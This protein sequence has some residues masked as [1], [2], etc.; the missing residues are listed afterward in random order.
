MVIII[1]TVDNISEKLW[2]DLKGEL[3]KIAKLITMSCIHYAEAISISKILNLPSYILM[4]R[5]PNQYSPKFPACMVKD[6]YKNLCLDQFS[7]NIILHP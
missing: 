4:A 3:M 2:R 5:S 6:H 7:H 1:I